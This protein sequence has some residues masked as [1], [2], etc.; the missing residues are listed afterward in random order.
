M[1]YVC[2]KNEDGKE[3][4]FTFP[5]TVNHDRFAE[6]LSMIKVD[7]RGPND[8]NREFRKPVS[9]GFIDQQGNCHGK[10]ETLRLN[11]RKEDTAIYKAQIK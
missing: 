1:K 3:E 7:G 8:W 4:I 6:V 2:V 10:S 11:S 5:R 9:A